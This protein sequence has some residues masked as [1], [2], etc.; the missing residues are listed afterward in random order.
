[1]CG[2][3]GPLS[4]VPAAG[5]RSHMVPLC[6]LVNTLISYFSSSTTTNNFPF[7]LVW[8]DILSLLTISQEVD[9]WLGH[10]AEATTTYP[11]STGEVVA[12]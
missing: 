4:A 12:L 8:L 6:G 5:F 9:S 2:D 11:T 3:K 1:M 7:C 10:K